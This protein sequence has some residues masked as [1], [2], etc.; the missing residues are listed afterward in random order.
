M[1]AWLYRAS[2][3]K[4][5]SAETWSIVKNLGFLHR[6]LHTQASKAQRI[7]NIGAVAVGDIIHLYYVGEGKGRAL[8]VLRVVEL[9]EHPRA[10]Q[11]GAAVPETALYTA[12]A[13]ELR[14]KLRAADYEVDPV[15]G[16]FCGWPVVRENRASPAYA[17]SLFPGRSSLVL[18]GDVEG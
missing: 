2:T 15:I 3:A 16:E 11:F 6:T 13:A 1:R 5:K 18:R 8:G 7:A 17:A 14:E 4:A 12:A 9:S 10:G